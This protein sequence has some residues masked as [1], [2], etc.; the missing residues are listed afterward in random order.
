MQMYYP[1][2][3]KGQKSRWTGLDPLLR[4]SQHQNQCVGQ[5]AFLTQAAGEES[6]PKPKQVVS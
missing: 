2:I 3:S 5:A 4:V 6:A 1:T